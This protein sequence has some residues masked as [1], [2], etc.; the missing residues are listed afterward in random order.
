M[1]MPYDNR[2]I[3]Q[4]EQR[5]SLTCLKCVV[6]YGEQNSSIPIISIGEPC[7]FGPFAGSTFCCRDGSDWWWRSARGPPANGETHG[8]SALKD[9][10]A[11]SLPVRPH[12][13]CEHPAQSLKHREWK[14][15]KYW[16]KGTVCF[17]SLS[18]QTK[19][20]RKNFERKPFLQPGSKHPL[21]SWF[22]LHHLIQILNASKC[23]YTFFFENKNHNNWNKTGNEKTQRLK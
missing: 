6:V 22:Y 19:T 18:W 20:P 3:H 17:S 14:E 16:R 12:A 2:L 21:R 10:N 13:S 15:A 11:R 9:G 8:A 4:T 23:Y 7:S 5:R 1:T